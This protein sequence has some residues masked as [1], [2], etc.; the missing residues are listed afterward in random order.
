[1]RLQGLEGPDDVAVHSR[2]WKQELAQAYY[3]AEATS[4]MDGAALQQLQ[5]AF[6]TLS[7]ASRLRAYSE[8]F[9]VLSF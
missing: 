4:F 1:M 8:S 3:A 6:E 2:Q 5:T 7:Q 9:V